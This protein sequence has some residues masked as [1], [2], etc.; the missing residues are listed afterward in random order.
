MTR[1]NIF[2]TVILLVLCFVSCKHEGL[3]WTLA[4]KL[5]KILEDYITA[6]PQDSIISVTFSRINGMNLMF[7]S[8]DN[9]YDKRRVD[10][11]SKK[12]TN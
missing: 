10:Y 2:L 5:N 9:R 3:Q 8:A 6:T 4:P 11:Y 7:I 1:K 12:V